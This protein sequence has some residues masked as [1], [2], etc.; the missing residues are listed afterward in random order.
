[1]KEELLQS[2][3]L[4]GDETRIQ[5]IDEPDQKGATR[6]WMWIYLTDEYSGAPRMVLFQ[7]ER[8]RAGYHPLEF[9]GDQFGGYF[10]CD[11]YQ[12]YHSPPERITVTGCTGQCGRIQY[13]RNSHA[14]RTKAIPCSLLCDGE[15]ERP[16]SISEKRSLA[17]TAPMVRQP[18]S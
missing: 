16:G 11:G 5:V 8:T 17:G 12:A 6:N 14:K 4:H 2:G 1:M 13:Y 15:N 9:L 10:T 7:Y 3:Y 18:A